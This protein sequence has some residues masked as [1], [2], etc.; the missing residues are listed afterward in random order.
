MADNV[1]VHKWPQDTP[2]WD[3]STKNS[4][5]VS[6]NKNSEKK[7][8]SIINNSIQIEEF[9]FNDIKKLAISIPFFKDE[10]RMIFEAQF[11]ELFA[12]V[13]IITKCDDFLDIFNK[14]MNWKQNYFQSNTTD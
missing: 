12:H 9:S 2:I 14:L 11:G 6:I 3:E 8:I 13:H 5:D 4:I 7:Q 10:C 1:H